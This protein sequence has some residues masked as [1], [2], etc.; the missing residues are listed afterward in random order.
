MKFDALESKVSPTLVK[1]KNLHKTRESNILT[2]HNILLTM[3]I[4]SCKNPTLDD[5]LR[6]PCVIYPF[7]EDRLAGACR[8][9][10]CMD[11][12]S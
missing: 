3:I 6:K 11:I 8:T 5:F 10:Q 12:A 4:P 2:S 1:A 9:V 7:P